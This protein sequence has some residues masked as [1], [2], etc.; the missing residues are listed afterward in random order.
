VRRVPTLSVRA[1]LALLTLAFVVTGAA[2]AIIAPLFQAPDE[3][4][5]VD[6]VRHYAEHPFTLADK[7]L[8][9]RN[10]VQEA[11]D[12]TGI[13]QGGTIDWAS[14]RIPAERPTYPSFDDQPNA[15]A[16]ATSCPVGTRGPDGWTS[17]QNYHYGHPPTFYEIMAI[18]DRALHGFGFPTELLVLRLLC[19]LLVAPIVPLTYYAARQ[20]WP[21]STAL[22]LGAATLVALFAPLAAAAGAVNND[23]MMLLCAGLYVAACARLLRRPSPGAAIAVGLAT[24]AGLLIKSNFQ[25]LAG[26]G[27][28]VVLVALTAIPRRDWVRTVVGFAVPAVVGS[29]FWLSNLVRFHTIGQPGGEIL[30]ARTPGTHSDA[31]FVGYSLRH[32]WDV[33]GRFWGLYGQSA[34]E[35]PSFWRDALS[36]CAGA[37]LVAGLL[38]SCHRWAADRRAPG[39]KHASGGWRMWALAVVPAVLLGG[40]LLSSFQVYAK[41]GQVRGLLGRY[42]Y[43][44]LPVFAIAA[45][46]ALASVAALV[47][48]RWTWPAGAVSAAGTGVAAVVCAAMVRRAI[49]GFYGTRSPSEWLDRMGRVSALGRPGPAL[50][51]LAVVWVAAVVAAGYGVWS[52]T[53]AAYAPGDAARYASA[54]P[55]P[56]NP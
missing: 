44:G 7:D 38:A 31:T 42:L 26:A 56:I 29:A 17:C 28:L 46:G 13:D 47:R 53:R 19:L 11:V 48:R 20:V 9:I 40:V 49:H 34:V 33:I 50:V 43:A 14:P 5:H 39:D 51:V 23:S 41:N 10:G 22:P 12:Q 15:G 16:P 24:G 1:H 25:A 6:M 54:Q 21:S 36:S 4:P 37:L 45:V 35:T 30:R 52:R 32:V 8:Q 55:R 27:G 18:P 3:P 2:F